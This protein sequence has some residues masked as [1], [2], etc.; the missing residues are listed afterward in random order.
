[1]VTR[2]TS[3]AE[4]GLGEEI[5]EVALT[6][7]YPDGRPHAATMGVRTSGDSKI[8]LRI[9]TDTDT[10]RNIAEN[11]SAVVNI[12]GDAGLLARL[13]LKDLLKFDE[14]ELEFGEDGKLND[15]GAW[16]KIEVE[17]LRKEQISDELGT[18]EVAHV[19]AGVR[20]I[21]VRD[22]DVRPLKRGE[23]PAIESAVLA[24][25]IRVALDNGK[26]ELAREMFEKIAELRERAAP[27]S[28]DSRLIA[29]IS[30]SLEIGD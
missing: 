25:R 30:D 10:F 7:F 14:S 16:V 27:G 28:S 2:M 21:D 11:R 13:A 22:P 9:F 8:L 12:V 24:T 18:A 6:T 20:G 29:E 23:S 4:I 1:M 3:L 5:A 19:T 15:A 17:E 26:Q